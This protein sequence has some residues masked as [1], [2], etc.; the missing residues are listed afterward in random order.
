MF[1]LNPRFW[2]VQLGNIPTPA[3]F[4]NARVKEWRFFEC[5]FQK[6]LLDPC[7]VESPLGDIEGTSTR[8]IDK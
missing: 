2:Y 5:F 6:I 4:H 7:I 8:S 1:Y 3:E